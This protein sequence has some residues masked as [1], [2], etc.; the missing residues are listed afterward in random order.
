[1]LGFPAESRRS[2]SASRAPIPLSAGPL[3]AYLALCFI[4][5]S[6]FLAIRVAVET[7][8]PWVMIGVRCL[9]AGAVLLAIAKAR[10]AV[11]PSGWAWGSAALSGVLLFAGS[12]A[13][14]S[15]SELRLPSGEAAVLVCTGSL[16]TPVAAWWLGASRRPPALALAGLAVGFAGVAA[17]MGAQSGGAQ[18]GHAA[19]RLAVLASSVSWAIGA[20]IAKRVPP[21]GSALLGSGLQLLAGAAACLVFALARGEFYHLDLAAVSGRSVL[22]VAYLIV[23]GSLVAFACFGW[24]VHLWPPEVLST[25]GFVN[26]VVALVLGAALAGERVG[27]REIGATAIILCGVALVVLGNMGKRSFL[28]KRTKKLLLQRI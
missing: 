21:A 22:A 17:L 11:W 23:M 8:P 10:G 2:M 1:M 3:A 24:L 14:L 12:Q 26:P 15:W 7:L 13:L 27:A 19:A 6:T 25:Y 18:A 20:G 5:G 9:V 4:W 28:K 16:F